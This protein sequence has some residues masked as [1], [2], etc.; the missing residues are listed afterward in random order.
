MMT[1]L[2][3]ARVEGDRL[4]AVSDR[5]ICDGGSGGPVFDDSGAAIGLLSRGEGRCATQLEYRL[6][7]FPKLGIAGQE[8]GW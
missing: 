6:L 3:T 5:E 4:L 7:D 1:Q 2:A 8:L